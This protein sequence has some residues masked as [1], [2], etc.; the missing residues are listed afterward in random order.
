MDGPER[1]PSTTT[2]HFAVACNVC[3]GCGLE[4]PK[5]DSSV[6]ETIV[7]DFTLMVRADTGFNPLSR[8]LV[9]ASS[10][11]Y[12][13]PCSKERYSNTHAYALLARASSARPDSGGGPSN[14]SLITGLSLPN[15]VN[16]ISNDTAERS[17]GVCDQL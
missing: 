9:E 7:N 1:Q 13:I 4:L 6:S 12:G 16:A 2:R 15:S 5:I 3:G 11:S 14:S 8:Q 10:I 17:N